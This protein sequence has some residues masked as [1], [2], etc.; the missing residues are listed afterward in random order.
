MELGMAPA[1]G[2]ER[3]SMRSGIARWG[4]GTAFRPSNLIPPGRRPRPFTG[5]RGSGSA[6][7]FRGPDA[8]RLDSEPPLPGPVGTALGSARLLG[9]VP[10]RVLLEL[11]AQGLARDAEQLRGARLV[12]LAHLERV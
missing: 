9:I 7:S 11:G 4:D 2:L 3:R 12:A 6:G 5:R 10:E 1:G 8:A